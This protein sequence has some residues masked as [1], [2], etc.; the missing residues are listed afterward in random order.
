MP[1][2]K[3]IDKI[4]DNLPI[5]RDEWLLNEQTEGMS[6]EDLMRKCVW[7]YARES[8]NLRDLSEQAKTLCEEN[9]THDSGGLG[10]ARFLSDFS[11]RW[12]WGNYHAAANGLS[13]GL[14]VKTN[15]VRILMN[16]H[17]QASPQDWRF[18]FSPLFPDVRVSTRDPDYDAL[19][20]LQW[21]PSPT[22]EQNQIVIPLISRAEGFVKVR[23]WSFD[24]L[25]LV[26]GQEVFEAE[27]LANAGMELRP[28]VA[29][30]LVLL[31]PSFVA[32]S[33]PFLITEVVE[34]LLAGEP[35]PNG[36]KI[37]GEIDT[38]DVLFRP[39]PA[40]RDLVDRFLG[41]FDTAEGFTG[42]TVM[43]SAGGMLPGRQAS[44]F[45][46]LFTEAEKLKRALQNH[47]I[48]AID[49]S[50]T[51]RNALKCLGALRVR[52]HI[53]QST[54]EMMWEE[55]KRTLPTID[56]KRKKDQ[57]RYD[58]T[59]RRAPSNRPIFSKWESFEDACQEAHRH[60][61]RIFPNVNDSLPR[62]VLAD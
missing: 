1:T 11:G 4:I 20:T 38:E 18:L 45:P 58:E 19:H 3:P 61:G 62:S 5:A 54:M 56:V 41:K 22:T 59:Y 42:F 13:G 16:I 47:Q 28:S 6:N 10:V 48:I 36:V 55:E 32:K 49:S 27:D 33:K 14:E 26:A 43:A 9:L 46:A 23:Q 39:D 30:I 52:R 53:D 57:F 60:F 8:D 37:T 24:G 25:F 2:P 29:A 31:S 15:L 51:C 21:N 35:N 12:Y 17:D 44:L 40:S 34:G 7:E 50:D